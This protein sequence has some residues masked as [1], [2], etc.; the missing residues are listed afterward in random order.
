MFHPAVLHTPLLVGGSQCIWVFVTAFIDVFHDPPELGGG[1]KALWVIFLVLFPFLGAFVYL[2][3]R[4]KSMAQRGAA[5]QRQAVACEA[6]Y[7]RT[8]AGGT[9]ATTEIESAKKLL[10]S[11]AITEAEFATLKAKALAS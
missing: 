4:A 2:I 6:D 10:D 8:V 9:S 11:G 1:A 7:I 3:A 5:A